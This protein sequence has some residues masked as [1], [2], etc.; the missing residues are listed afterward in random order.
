MEPQAEGRLNN[1]TDAANH[2]CS[3][4]KSNTKS[5]GIPLTIMCSKLDFF[6]LRTCQRKLRGKEE[7]GYLRERIQTPLLAEFYRLVTQ[8]T[9]IMNR[10]PEA[11]RER[12]EAMA[13]FHQ[14]CTNA[15]ASRQQSLPL[16]PAVPIYHG[17]RPE[18]DLLTGR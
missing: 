8:Q 11:Q 1:C 5:S 15:F 16:F 12:S 4:D 2:K 17:E 6:N 9:R 14:L 3:R 13:W 10:I 7:K 18:L